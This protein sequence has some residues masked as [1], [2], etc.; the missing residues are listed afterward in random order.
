MNLTPTTAG[1]LGLAAPASAATI[2]AAVHPTIST[3][4]ATGVRGRPAGAP[5]LPRGAAP[6]GHPPTGVDESAET[7]PPRM[8]AEPARSRPDDEGDATDSS[9]R[10]PVMAVALLLAAAF[11]AAWLSVVVV[12]GPDNG[13]THGFLLACAAMVWL[14]VLTRED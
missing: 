13:L 14:A 1:G 11:G 5:R 10:K 4:G 2:T 9:P 8:E 12:A 7:S 3:L 6:M